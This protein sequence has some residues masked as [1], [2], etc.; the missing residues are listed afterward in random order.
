MSIPV[1]IVI[2]GIYQCAMPTSFQKFNVLSPFLRPSTLSWCDLQLFLQLSTNDRSS[3]DDVD[4][5]KGSGEHWMFGKVY[6][7]RLLPDS[8]PNC[9]RM[10]FLWRGARIQVP[11]CRIEYLVWSKTWIKVVL[12]D[13]QQ[14]HATVWTSQ[15]W[16]YQLF[17][18]V[19]VHTTMNM[20]KST[21]EYVTLGPSCRLNQSL[22][23]NSYVFNKN[24]SI[25]TPYPKKSVHQW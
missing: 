14:M 17:E 18:L 1:N 16:E 12:P 6:T 22:I 24:L 11:Y 3:Q 10:E 20:R 9:L 23:V 15:C 8:W 21:A 25:L 4:G 13:M 7:G 2:L 5:G 19:H